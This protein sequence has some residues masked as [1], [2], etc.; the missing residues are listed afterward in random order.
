MTRG[1][2]RLKTECTRVFQES[3]QKLLVLTFSPDQ[4]HNALRTGLYAE[5]LD[6]SI[7]CHYDIKMLSLD[8][9][10]NFYHTLLA[11]LQDLN[12]IITADD[13]VLEKIMWNN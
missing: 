9:L 8:N 3:V 2:R 13:N 6:A 5:T 7:K 10:P 11:Y 1:P 12:S 4:A